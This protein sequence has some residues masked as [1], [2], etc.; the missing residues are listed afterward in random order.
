MKIYEIIPGKLYQSK[1]TNDEDRDDKIAS[2]NSFGITIIVNMWHTTDMDLVPEVDEYIKFPMSDGK[3]IDLEAYDKMARTLVHM[4][5]DG[6]CVLVHC[7]GG[8]NRSGLL[9]AIIVMYLKRLNGKQAHAYILS[10]R[11]NSLVNKEFCKMLDSLE[12]E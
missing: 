10:K 1:K 4:I 6:H 7:Y 12:I 3:T 8:R 9:N 5:R 11:P 2:I